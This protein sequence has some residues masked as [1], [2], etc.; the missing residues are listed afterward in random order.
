M[1]ALWSFFVSAISIALYHFYFNNWDIQ[2]QNNQKLAHRVAEQEVLFS[3]R[4]NAVFRSSQPTDFIASAEASRKAVVFIRI[5]HSSFTA[6]PENPL[7]SSHS[8]SG[9]II[10]ADGYIVTNEH[11]VKNATKLEI[12]LND[13]RVFEANVIGSDPNTDLALLKIESTN[14][15]FLVFGNSDSLKIGEWVMAVGNPFRL[16]ST[17]TAGIVSAKARNINLLEHQGIEAFIQTDAAVNPGNSGGALINTR[18]DLVGICTAILSNSGKYEGFSFAIPSNLAKK[19]ISDL[20]EYGMVQRGWLG[21]DFEN[22]DNHMASELGLPNVA[23]I[24]VTSVYKDGGAYLAGVRS[25]DV[26]LSVNGIPT[27]STAEFMEQIALYRPGDVVVLQGFRD[28][29]SIQL[30]AVLR[31]QLNST[32]L[33]GIKNTEFFNKLGLEVRDLDKYENA[34]YTSK[35]IMVVSVTIGSVV[36]ETKMAP[37]YIITKV[38]EKEVQSVSSLQFQLEAN[39]GKTIIIEGFYPKYRGAYPYTFFMPN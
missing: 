8:G 7:L 29:K 35:G 21:I 6:K 30:K 38:N 2:L 1:L 24:F 13:N 12:T 4:F 36:G 19:V 10:S 33:V 11:V 9:V 27:K 34:V 15:D 39:K 28:K 31:N 3:D 16:Q 32:D 5:V 25:N 23:G 17:V 22:V 37:G 18:G 26:I 14:L 20:R